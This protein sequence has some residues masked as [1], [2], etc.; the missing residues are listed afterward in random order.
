MASFG[1]YLAS[2]SAPIAKRV[3]VGLGIGVVSYVGLD[4]VFN[5]ILVNAQSNWSAI[6]SGVANMMAIVG[7]ND[8]IGIVFGALT[9]RLA[10]I[11]L[12]KLGVVA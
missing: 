8:A 10:M 12:K 6:P 4:A 1:V 9:T 3:L 5:Q 7:I 2:I 11:Q